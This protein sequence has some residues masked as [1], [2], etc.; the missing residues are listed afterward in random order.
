MWKIWY[1]SYYNEFITHANCGKPKFG[2]PAAKIDLNI[3]F[4]HC[5][6]LTIKV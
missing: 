1:I 3:L 4:S 6:F 5:V 2:I